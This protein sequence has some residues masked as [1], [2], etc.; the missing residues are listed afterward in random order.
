ML[1]IALIAVVVATGGVAA[2]VAL[3]KLIRLATNIAYF[4]QFNLA[5]RPLSASPLGL[6]AVLVPVAGALVIGLMARYGSEKIRGHGIPEAIEAILLGRSR[7]DVR[8]AV[9]KP[10]SSAVVIGTGGPFG[11]EG[12]IIMTGGAIGSLIA[13]LLPVSDTERKTL[14]VAGAAAGM[15]TVF[16]TPIAAIMLAVELL[17]FEWSP[18]SFIPVAVAAIVAAVERTALHMPTPLFPFAGEVQVSALALGSWV[19]IG[20][21]AGLLSGLL[22]Q[23]VYACEDAFLKLPI[24]WMWWPMLGGLVVGLGGLIAPNALGV[25]YDNI[26]Q[27]PQG[28]MLVSA[29]APLLVVK[30]VIWSVA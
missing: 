25:G 19:M 22:T 27:M 16:G 9:L 12:P 7:M 4:G 24:H 14:L 29:A 28:H 2:G 1:L 20:V 5:D 10:L 26:T 17:L 30:A 11:A 3:L 23:M 18:R 15:T 21:L 13:Q 6:W 8:V